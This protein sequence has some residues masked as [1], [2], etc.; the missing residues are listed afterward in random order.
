MSDVTPLYLF[1]DGLAERLMRN[2]FAKLPENTP[3]KCEA[4]GRAAYQAPSVAVARAWREDLVER[5]AKF[6]PSA[7][8]CFEEGFEA[9]MA[10]LRCPVVARPLA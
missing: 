3:A 1:L 9:C 6:A 4:A 5:F 2:F 7:V 10:P 8:C